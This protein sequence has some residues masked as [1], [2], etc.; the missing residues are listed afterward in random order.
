[1]AK[2]SPSSDDPN[3]LQPPTY[4]VRESAPPEYTPPSSYNVGGRVVKQP[5]VTVEQL[6]AHLA[7]LRAFK[8]LRTVVEDGTDSR[9][10][11]DIRDLETPAL[12]WARIVALAVERCV[13]AI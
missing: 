4:E 12:R 7:L 1:M 2:E 13:K 6:K 8:E 10:P 3:H 11:S 9:L 5:F